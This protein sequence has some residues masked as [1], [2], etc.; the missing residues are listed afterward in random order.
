[1]GLV[2]LAMIV[3][4]SSVASL[5]ARAGLPLG[6][7][8]VGWFTLGKLPSSFWFPTAFNAQHYLYSLLASLEVITANRQ[9]LF[10][11]IRNFWHHAYLRAGPCYGDARCAGT[12]ME[13]IVPAPLACSA[14]SGAFYD[15]ILPSDVLARMHLGALLAS[16]I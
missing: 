11:S 16:A 10:S 5:Q 13:V 9:H 7:Q 2:A 4:R 14:T 3:T 1:M 6:T 15:N 12:S 8:M